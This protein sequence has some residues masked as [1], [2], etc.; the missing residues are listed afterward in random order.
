M[1]NQKQLNELLELSEKLGIVC[2][3]ASLV[4]VNNVKIKI[5]F[6]EKCCNAD[7][8]DLGLSVRAY[9]SLKR[10]GVENVFGIVEMISGDR[11]SKVRNLGRKTEN[12]IKTKLLDFGY[13]GLPVNCKREFIR[14]TLEGEFQ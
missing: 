4:G 7:I 9:N 10:A 2:V 14:A 13:R 1:V 12:E 6:T 5:P 11:L 8:E 3:V